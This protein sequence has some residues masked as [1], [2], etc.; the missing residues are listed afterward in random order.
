MEPPGGNRHP[1]G[2]WV[3]VFWTSLNLKVMVAD[4]LKEYVH[5]ALW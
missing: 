4:S 5:L 3:R 2:D 1:L